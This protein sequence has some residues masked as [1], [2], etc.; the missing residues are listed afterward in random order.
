MIKWCC[1]AVMLPKVAKLLTMIGLKFRFFSK[2]MTD[3]FSGVVSQ[4][5]KMRKET[6]D[7]VRSNSYQKYS[8]AL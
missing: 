5:M 4:I 8:L 1:F 6:N 2:E 7:K 3:F